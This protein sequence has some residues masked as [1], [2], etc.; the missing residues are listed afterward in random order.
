M[1]AHVRVVQQGEER[2]GTTGRRAGAID[3]EIGQRIK[4]VRS[5]R[6]I[7]QEDLA[8][9]LGISSQQLQ[10][11]ENGTNRISVSRLVEVA[12]QLGVEI[13][14]LL[15]DAAA[16]GTGS[17]DAGGPSGQEVKDLVIAFCGIENPE[18]RARV[19]DMANFFFSFGAGERGAADR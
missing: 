19:L 17:T 15:T 7:T 3:G 4:L 14:E 9:R 16:S 11:Y 10:K 2:G 5:N 18:A 6:R 1:P 13:S 8:A 12:R